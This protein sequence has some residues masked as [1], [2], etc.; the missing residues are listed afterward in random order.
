[1]EDSLIC[2]IIQLS[3]ELAEMRFLLEYRNYGFMQKEFIEGGKAYI[4]NID[5]NSCVISHIQGINYNKQIEVWQR[6]W[7]TCQKIHQEILRHVGLEKILI[8]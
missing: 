8:E 6:G 2:V 4:Q 3:K 5:I 1:M 7:S